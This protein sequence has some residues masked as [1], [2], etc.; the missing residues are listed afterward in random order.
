MNNEVE[1]LKLEI[2]VLKKRVAHL[3][4]IENRRKIIAII[5]ALVIVIMIGIIVYF[6]LKIYGKYTE[7]YGQFEEFYQNP[8]KS[9][10]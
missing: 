1:S 6:S 4:G 8:L 10:F 9:F 3:E 2:E 5:K 7:M